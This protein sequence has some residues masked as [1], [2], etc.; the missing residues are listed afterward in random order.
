MM[1][2]S[3]MGSLGFRFGVCQFDLATSRLP[4]AES[5]GNVG[6][7]SQAH[8]LRGLSGERRALSGRA[9]KYETPVLSENRLVVLARGVDPEFE[10]AA[11]TMERAGHTAL[12]VELANVAQVDEHHITPPNERNRFARRQ[13]L[14]LA[15]GRRAQRP[16]V[17]G[18][19]RRH[20]ASLP[21]MVGG[22]Q[23]ANSE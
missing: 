6:D 19:V 1:R 8:P 10:H 22:V 2:R 16:D 7:R 12:T 20:I 23:A 9:E 18:D 14:D 5:A 13:G 15:L 11:R 21:Q 4:G 3:A 17:G